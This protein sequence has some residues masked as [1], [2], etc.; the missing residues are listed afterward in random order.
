MKRV[1][2]AYSWAVY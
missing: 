1:A 2:R